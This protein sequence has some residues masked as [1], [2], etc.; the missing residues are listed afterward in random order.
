MLD[1]LE[2]ERQKLTAQLSADEAAESPDL[3][4][5]LDRL[6]EETKP[7]SVE[8]VFNVMLHY[9]RNYADRDTKQPL[10]DI[11]RQLIQK[12]LVGHMPGHE[13]ASLQVHGRIASILAAMEATTILEKQLKSI[14][15][16]WYLEAEDAGRLET[17]Q[18][19]QDLFKTMADDLEEKKAKW[20]NLQVSVVAG[21]GFEPAAFRL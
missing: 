16:G 1:N 20:R 18:K 8:Y 9:L 19:R 7:E 11:V 14:H 17:E 3:Q 21:A 13:P 12:V 15:W 2:V 10:V 4:A 6:Y 5:Q